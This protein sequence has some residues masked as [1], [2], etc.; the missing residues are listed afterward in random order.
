MGLRSSPEGER[1]SCNCGAVFGKKEKGDRE[2]SEY[3]SVVVAGEGEEEV[4]R[5]VVGR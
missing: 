3:V 1:V 4:W 5:E 2:R